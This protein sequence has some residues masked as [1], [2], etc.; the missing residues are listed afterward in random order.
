LAAQFHFRRAE[1]PFGLQKVRI[2]QGGKKHPDEYFAVAGRAYL[3]NAEII[4][5]DF[6]VC[7]N[8]PELFH[9]GWMALDEI[10]QSKRHGRRGG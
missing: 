5:K 1:M 9:L 8:P 4:R 7:E 10:G 3:G 2:D 6:R